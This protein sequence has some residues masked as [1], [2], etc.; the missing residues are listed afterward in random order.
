MKLDDTLLKRY[1]EVMV[2]YG[3][4]N[5]NGI[6]AGDT[7]FLTGQECAQDLYLAIAKEIY[8]AGGNVINN[9]LPNNTR[10]SSLARFVIENGTQEQIGFFAQPYWQGVVDA[11]DHMLFIISDPDIHYLEGL[12]A[13]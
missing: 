13:A 6:K 5:G 4:N 1:A 10:D 12:T 9:Y 7:V 11:T 8:L 3:L 2:Q